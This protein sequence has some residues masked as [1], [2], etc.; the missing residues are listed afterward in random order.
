MKDTIFTPNAPAPIGPY[1][2]AVKTGSLVFLSGQLPI[3]P[4]TGALVKGIAAETR[5]VFENIRAVL[6]AAGSSLDKVV[7]VNV[8]MADLAEFTEMNQV[9]AGY[10]PAHPPARLTVQVAALPKGA[11]IEID[12]VAEV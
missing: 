7:K 9:Y 10:F 3:D 11:G 8:Y 2:Q 12:V 1:C 6:E 4:K 5:Q